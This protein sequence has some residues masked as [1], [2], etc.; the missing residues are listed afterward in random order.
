MHPGFGKADDSFQRNQIDATPVLDHKL[1]TIAAV[2]QTVP[3]CSRLLPGFERLVIRGDRCRHTYQE[4]DEACIRSK[5]N[6]WNDHELFSS[7][8]IGDIV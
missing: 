5:S 6:E 1:Q 8:S 2:Q 7:R 3:C 4:G